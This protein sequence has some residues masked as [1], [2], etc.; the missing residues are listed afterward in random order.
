MKNGLFVDEEAS[1]DAEHDRQEQGR[2]KEMEEQ[3]QSEQEQ[4]QEQVIGEIVPEE[5]EPQVEPQVESQ[6]ESQSE[7]SDTPEVLAVPAVP[8][9]TDLAYEQRL[10]RD[11]SRTETFLKQAD[12]AI[13]NL[14]NGGENKLDIEESNFEGGILDLKI[15]IIALYESYKTLT[16]FPDK[17]DSIG[18]A[19]T[20][21]V[22]NSLVDEHKEVAKHYKQQQEQTREA[23]SNNKKVLDEFSKF[24]ELLE[25][26]IKQ[27]KTKLYR[28]DD[29]V[30]E[31]KDTDNQTEYI[32][33]K[34]QIGEDTLR[35]LLEYEGQVTEYV[36]YICQEHYNGK[37]DE[38]VLA[39]FVGSLMKSRSTKNEQDKWVKLSTTIE[40]S[41]FIKS[42]VLHD[43][44]VA[45]IGTPGVYKLRDFGL[46]N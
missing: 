40:N 17:N 43:L 12:I 22:L 25:E 11:I 14:L 4:E 23:L 20:S 38:D 39:E 2:E 26:E 13:E 45:R 42:L 19:T 24:G 31:I 6:V 10:L 8:D 37:N 18:T 34:I 15:E 28:I 29:E 1:S 7:P 41:K 36:Q 33:K 9:P 44:I 5:V 32:E 27:Q 46:N 35:E 3:E 21:T 30:T 16:Y